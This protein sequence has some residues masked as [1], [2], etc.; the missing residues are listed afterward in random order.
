M[1]RGVQVPERY[2]M[3]DAV[4]F[5]GTGRLAA[6]IYSRTDLGRLRV[7]FRGMDPEIDAQLVAMQ[8]AAYKWQGR[9][10]R[11]DD[12]N[13]CE[14]VPLCEWLTVAEVASLLGLTARAVQKAIARGELKAGRDGRRYKIHRDDFRH[15]QA[16]RTTRGEPDGT[17]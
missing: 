7:E 10:E 2:L 16:A 12:A 5:W 8:I 1:S 9:T 15:Y 11:T 3:P 14:T 4:G 6:L 17:A 13:P